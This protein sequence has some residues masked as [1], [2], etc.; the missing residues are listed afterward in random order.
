MPAAADPPLLSVSIWLAFPIALLMIVMGV[1]FAFLKQKALA[2]PYDPELG[3]R[4]IW[5]THPAQAQCFAITLAVVCV[6][7]VLCGITS[8]TQYSGIDESIQTE[9]ATEDF[10]Q[11]RRDYL[12]HTDAADELRGR[13]LEIILGYF[14]LLL[15]MAEVA[16]S[17]TP[18]VAKTAPGEATLPSTSRILGIRQ[19]GDK[20]QHEEIQCPCRDVVPR[21][22]L[23][24][25]CHEA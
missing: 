20:L 14:S 24:F 1:L 13:A 6:M 2:E 5:E 11:I 22:H 7:L 8:I 17:T 16:L 15:F 12:S 18:G 25:H 3:Q 9:W 23:R 10:R 19:R 21:E 4:T